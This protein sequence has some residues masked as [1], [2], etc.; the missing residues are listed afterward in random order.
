MGIQV[1]NALFVNN[2]KIC[3]VGELHL[4]RGSL[5]KEETA[6]SWGSWHVD[7]CAVSMALRWCIVFPFKSF[8]LLLNNTRDRAGNADLWRK[9][10]GT[11]SPTH[12]YFALTYLPLQ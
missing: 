6:L 5:M 7:S 2:G 3:G 1:I 9:G 4:A 8:I 11:F 12:A 10:K